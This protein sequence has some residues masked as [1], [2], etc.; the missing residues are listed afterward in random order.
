ML[1]GPC[2]GRASDPQDDPDQRLKVE[3]ADERGE[4]RGGGRPPGLARDRAVEE[5][6]ESDRPGRKDQVA[7][8][9][10]GVEQVVEYRPDAESPLW[11]KPA[12]P[13]G[14]LPCDPGGALVGGWRRAVTLP[15]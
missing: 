7:E 6:Q 13:R 10:V 8:P 1:D 15:A 11:I 2:D 3:E 4:G 14:R 5:P 12:S 9:R